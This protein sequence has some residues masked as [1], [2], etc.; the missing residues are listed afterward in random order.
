[1]IYLA[2]FLEYVGIFTFLPTLPLWLSGDFGMT[3]QQA[4][5]WASIFSILITLFLFLVG[6]LADAIGVRRMLLLSFGLAAVTRLLMALATTSTG[7]IA[8]L[9]AFALAYGAT[10]PG[11]QTAIQR[12]ST[13]STRAFA[14]SLWYVSFNLAGT[15][16]GPLIDTTRAAFID[17]ATKKLVPHVVNLPILGPR[18]MSAYAVILGLGFVS[19]AL[20]VLVMLL[21]R[22]DFEHRADP[23]DKPSVVEPEAVEP[24][25]EPA[26]LDREAS[27]AT[28]AVKVEP[29]K[30]S[31]LVALREVI[32]DRAFWR[33]MLMLLLLC[34][35]RMMFQ[36][37][38]FT[39]PKYVTRVNGDEF[40]V[41]YVWSFNSFLILFL[42]PLGTAITRKQKPFNV[43]LI[44]A[45]ISSLSPFVLCFGNSMPYQIGMVLFL[46]VGEA[47]WSPRLY[48]YNVS[49][50]PRG[51]EATYVSLA[52]LPYF[53]AKFLVGPSSGYLLSALCPAGG[54]YRTSLLWG[55][56]GIS[57]MVGPTGIFLLRNV[58]Q[59]KE[60]ETPAPAAALDPHP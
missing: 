20:A 46:T 21:L 42:A 15:I 34:L 11:L 19:A 25:L 30:V 38:H 17:P 51:R 22:R 4:G 24:G 54:P 35:V 60:Q 39:W 50:A 52:A 1:M 7:A 40:P 29:K 6:S 13:R 58:I 41:G 28:P 32:A 3:D 44:G 36:H 59:K 45:F 27:A 43:L 10:S 16:S 23:E 18:M 14:F 9:M 31:P 53:L 57:T 33:F 26:P 49:I 55:I 5:W 8:A 56:I 2:T 47:L 37:M 48:E 12:T